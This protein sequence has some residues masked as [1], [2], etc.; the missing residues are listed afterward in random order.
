[1][2]N[3]GQKQALNST[4]GFTCVLAGAGTGKTFTITQIVKKL[5]ARGVQPGRI[6]LVTFTR[7]AADEMRERIGNSAV[8]AMTYHA[9]CAKI[10]RRY[11]KRVGISPR[12][13]LM[14]TSDVPAAINLACGKTK[15]T[16]EE[17]AR[18]ISR[19]ANTG[20]SYAQAA[21][22]CRVDANPATIEKM[23]DRYM[24]YKL[25]H[26]LLDYDDLLTFTK[27]LFLTDEEVRSKVD[28]SF[29]YILVDEYQDTNHVQDEIILS[30][31]QDCQNLLVVGDDAQS[32]YKFRGAEVK[33]IITF[34]ERT[35]GKT[36]TLT[37]NYRSTKN[38]LGLSNSIMKNHY[39]G[40]KKILHGIS[41]GSEPV[42]VHTSDPASEY[43]WI[44]DDIASRI[45]SG[46]T[47]CVLGRFSS[48]FDGMEKALLARG[49][50]CVRRGG[51]GFTDTATF[52]NFV[53]FFRFAANPHDVLAE[54]RLYQLV[55][56]VGAAR[57]L[58]I[59]EGQTEAP[60]EV[61]TLR[62]IVQSMRDD[63]E[64]AGDLALA[65]YKAACEALIDAT[66]KTRAE[67]GLSQAEA[68]K[69]IREGNYDE[70]LVEKRMEMAMRKAKDLTR[71]D[72][73]VEKLSLVL[74]GY[75]GNIRE[76]LDN[77]IMEFTEDEKA[78]VVLSTVHSAKGLEWDAVYIADVYHGTFP[79]WSEDPEDLRC[80]Y[81]AM[82]RA[83]KRLVLVQPAKAMGKYGPYDTK[84]SEYLEGA[85][86][87]IDE[88]YA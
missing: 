32:I 79:S 12:Y 38:V 13:T 10:L 78:Q 15:V 57:A 3:D 47:F 70:S 56:G 40:N 42:L 4:E 62:S 88:E 34:P 20:E 65:G 72:S 80:F 68:D 61:M 22:Y 19:C 24:A 30:I 66:W 9:F 26:Q 41:S 35:R 67:K 17:A 52:Q 33:N 43:S 36:V 31:R 74:K 58:A 23:A 28:G 18:V 53:A 16:P 44:A 85:E 2:L 6:L 29:D 50:S 54:T 73:N 49:I 86:S 83:K 81:V 76:F 71:L 39:T 5:I 87:F 25:A 11:G 82:T 84:R 14:G 46:E 55:Y 63:Q 59:A 60:A 48:M 75:H 45:D 21:A 1:M 8:P 64:N 51:R 27:T 77:T 37:E 69:A 7:K